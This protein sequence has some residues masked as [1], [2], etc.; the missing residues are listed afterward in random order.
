MGDDD[1]GDAAVTPSGFQTLCGFKA[2]TVV[3]DS[4]PADDYAGGRLQVVLANTCTNGQ[5]QRTVSQDMAGILDPTTN[6]PLLATDDLAL[7]GGGDAY[8]RVNAY[9]LTTSVWPIVATMGATTFTWSDRSDGTEIFTA[10][11]SS[12]T[13][14]HDYGIV[15]LARD[16][17]GGASMLTAWGTGAPGTVAAAYLFETMIAPALSTDRYGW[18]VV[19]WTNGDGDPN[20]TPGDTLT[21]LASGT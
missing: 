16:P 17:V 11:Y 8:Q 3:Q 4:L 15:L 2:L 6:R 19:E 21:V 9:F 5:T 13:G 1:A 20:P 7:V 14:T 12:L 18:Y 10:P